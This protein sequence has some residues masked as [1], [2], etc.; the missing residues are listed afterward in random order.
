M[1]SA[2]TQKY[3]RA[4]TGRESLCRLENQGAEEEN[5][6]NHMNAATPMDVDTHT[7]HEHRGGGEAAEENEDKSDEY[8]VSERHSYQDEDGGPRCFMG[9]K[10]EGGWQTKGKSKVKGKCDGARRNCGKM[11]HRNRNWSE[12]CL[13]NEQAN[14]RAKENTP[15]MSMDTKVHATTTTA[16]TR[17]EASSRACA[18]HNHLHL[19]RIPSIKA[20]ILESDS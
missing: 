15:R 11:G 9:K 13:R 12:R 14:R 6:H 1:A 3:S 4:Q 20:Q 10:S 16:A 18:I 5:E 17:E 2:F 8:H 7:H 19:N